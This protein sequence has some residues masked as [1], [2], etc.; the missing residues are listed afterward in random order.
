MSDGGAL[1]K[2]KRYGGSHVKAR[3]LEHSTLGRGEM[4]KS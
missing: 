3:P 4:T 2:A 1:L